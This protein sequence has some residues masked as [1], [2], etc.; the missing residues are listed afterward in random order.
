MTL[1][2]VLSLTLSQAPGVEGMQ[3][4]LRSYFA[5]ESAEAWAFGGLGL[6]SLG[7][8]VG[9]LFGGTGAT[10]GAAVP[11]LSVGLI[12]AVLAIGLWVRTPGQVAGLEAQ[13]AADASAYRATEGSRMERVMRGFAVY[14]A[15]EVALFFGGLGLSGAG[16]TLKSDF[17]LGAGFT[18][19]AEALVMLV[20]DFYAEGRGRLYQAAISG[21]RF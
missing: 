3:R 20:L 8:G 15:A 17:A 2:L 10:R 19:A 4:D 6:V 18:L 1:A 21:F 5:G 11:L 14:K 7:S 16:G 13:L 12:Q 9:L